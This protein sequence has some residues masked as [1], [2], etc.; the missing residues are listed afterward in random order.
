MKKILFFIFFYYCNSLSAQEQHPKDS[1]S[2]IPLNEVIVIGTT[3]VKHQKQIKPLASLDEY[4]EQSSKIN[5]IKRGG[6]AWEPT[7]NGMASERTSITI[8]GMQIFGAC[9][10]KM[11]PI[12]SYVEISNLQEAHISS[13]QQGSENNATIG[14]SIDLKRKKSSFNDTEWGAN[15]D[16]GYE[17][18]GDIKSYGLGTHYSSKSFFANTNFMY[19]DA[20]NY[21]AGK[22]E[23]ILYSQYTKYN[24]ST[25]MGIRL[26]E[27]KSIEGSFIFDEANDV[28]YPALPMDVSLARALIASLSYEQKDLSPIFK[29]WESKIYYNTIT[30]KMDDSK[31]PLVPIRMDMPGWSDTYGFYSKLQGKINQHQFIVNL[32]SYH[33]TSK[34]E[35]TMYPNNPDESS[36]FMLTWPDVTTWDSGLYIEDKITLKEN[37]AFKLST[38]IGFHSNSISDDFG[39][40]SLQIFYPELSKTKQRFLWNIAGE[41]IYQKNNFE[42]ILGTGYGER[43]PSVSEGYGFYLFNSF[44]GYDYI[45]NPNLKNEKSLEGN[46]AIRYKKNG[47]KTELTTSYFHI[48]NYIIGKQDPSLSSMTIGA[49]GVR[50]YSALDYVSLWNTDWSAEYRFTNGLQWKGK[51]GYTYGEGSDHEKIPLLRPF[52]Y[53][54]SLGYTYKD[55]TTEIAIQGAENQSRYSAEYGERETPAYTLCNWY[56]GYVL[57][58]EKTK[59]FLKLG[60]ENIFDKRYSTYSDWNH[61]LRKGRNVFLSASFTI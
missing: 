5:M 30:H 22:G 54:V 8:D 59:L 31:R 39:L 26:A 16:T 49:K 35:M 46:L 58:P 43:A 12:T 28:G 36:M 57:Y 48:M 14:G 56:A 25:V 20:T 6:Y 41:Y 51:I 2:T 52:S 19:R 40:N 55:F 33:N 9:T 61:I 21:K 24:F 45:G 44:D 3:E 23:E 10:D 37:K 17:T 7:I 38:R 4:L 13:G 11:D 15:F 34:A 50:I 47:F 1:I 29:K 53:S 32:N 18:N 60:I 27:N 42:Y